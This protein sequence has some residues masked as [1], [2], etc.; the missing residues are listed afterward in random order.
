MPIH[1]T[2]AAHP[3]Q[4]KRL[5]ALLCALADLAERAAG[6]S[7]AVCWLVI[8]LL[9]PSEAVARAYLEGLTPGVAWPA[10]PEPLRPR[11]GAAEARR[12]AESLRT[13]AALLAALAAYGQAAR[14]TPPENRPGPVAAPS[15]C[16]V[17]PAIAGLDS[18]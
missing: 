15:F 11:D 5:A 6:R 13:L 4:L 16:P 18:S 7:R 14:P 8:W 10:A 1:P 17:S 2:I 9:R 3:N 12:L